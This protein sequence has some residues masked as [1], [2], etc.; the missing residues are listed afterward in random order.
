MKSFDGS[1][2]LASA[3]PRR[4]ELLSKAGYKFTI[5]PSTVDEAD[6]AV[7]NIESCKYAELLALEKAKD[8]AK[9]FPNKLIL[10]A[11]TIVDYSGEIIGK[12]SNKTQ[13]EQIIRKLFSKSHKVITGLA[14]LKLDEGIEIVQSDTTIVYP[15]KMTDKQIS[16]HLQSGIWKGKAGAYAIQENGDEFVE[17]IEGSFTNVMGM[18]MELTEKLLR[19]LGVRS[20]K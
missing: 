1:F 11:D 16:E 9:K 6:F 8:V 20:E 13:A 18:P 5:F 17:R 10:A 12:P 19:D 7:E 14:I 2:I 15:R 3:S 4:K